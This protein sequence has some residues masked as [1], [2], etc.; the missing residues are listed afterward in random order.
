MFHSC[1]FYPS[2]KG[3]TLP[4]RSHAL[5]VNFSY[6]YWVSDPRRCEIN[7][8]SACTKACE[9]VGSDTHCHLDGTNM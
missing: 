8:K 4:T 2:D 6:C 9:R 5:V 7:R 3:V 1:L